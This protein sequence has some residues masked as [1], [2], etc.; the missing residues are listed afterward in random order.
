M[1]KDGG[2]EARQEETEV[3]MKTESDCGRQEATE[4][5]GWEEANIFTLI[6]IFTKTAMMDPRTWTVLQNSPEV[7]RTTTEGDTSW[8]RGNT[9]QLDKNVN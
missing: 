9:S 8:L 2:R 3:N 5:E 6:L 7:D 4:G 1:E